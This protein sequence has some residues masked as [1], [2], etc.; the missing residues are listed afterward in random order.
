[1]ASIPNTANVASTV[2]WNTVIRCACDQHAR[3]GT[4]RQRVGLHV[5]HH[6][7]RK[8]LVHGLLDLGETHD[9]DALGIGSRS[10]DRVVED[11]GRSLRS[12][13][14]SRSRA[15][16]LPLAVTFPRTA[17][18]SRV[19]Q[20]STVMVSREIFPLPAP[21]STAPSPRWSG[22]GIRV[23][24]IVGINEDAVFGCTREGWHPDL[25][26]RRGHNARLRPASA[27][28][29]PI[30]GTLTSGDP[31]CVGAHKYTRNN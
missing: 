16:Y 18:A 31:K 14:G 29:R 20:D 12:V 23:R 8:L 10:I 21:T 22:E 2:R 11:A 4:D 28:F 27:H 19:W 15:L 1:V 25:G 9:G 6:P 7:A 30:G 3:P 24:S 13:H 5:Q 17:P 26:V